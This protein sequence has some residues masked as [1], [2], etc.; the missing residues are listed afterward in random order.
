MHLDQAKVWGKREGTDGK[1]AVIYQ[2]DNLSE[3]DFHAALLEVRISVRV[4]NEFRQFPLTHLR[5][6]IP[7]N[8]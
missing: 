2:I 3:V 6:S 1:G 5:G 4:M 8:E 7:E